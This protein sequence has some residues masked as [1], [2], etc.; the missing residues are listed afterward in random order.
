[1]E[2]GGHDSIAGKFRHL[3]GETVEDHENLSQDG[4]APSRNSNRI[5]L[6]YKSDAFSLSPMLSPDMLFVI[7]STSIICM[8]PR[9]I[10]RRIFGMVQFQ[11]NFNQISL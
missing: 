7:Y 8:C 11:I 6:E 4:H 9:I 10:C 2:G 1:M 3:S 5:S